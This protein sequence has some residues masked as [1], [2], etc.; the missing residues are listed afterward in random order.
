MATL[1]PDAL[2]AKTMVGMIYDIQNRSGDARQIYEEIVKATERAPVA[3][4]NLAWHYAESGEKLD[5]ALQLAQSA[6]RQLPD[7]HE[8]DDTLGWVYYKRNMPELAIPP[9]ER[10][11]KAF[12]QSAQYHAHL[13][14]AYAKAGRTQQARRS[15]QRAL[16]LKS[17]FPGA[18]D[19]RSALASLGQ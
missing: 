10:A 4:N 1:N 16:E 8:V 7:S 19:V 6:K 11:V 17:D 5:M 13:G 3:A 18:G 14:L 12:E 15:L 9:L 2:G